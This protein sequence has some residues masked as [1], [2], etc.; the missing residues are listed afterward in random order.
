M[1]SSQRLKH[2]YAEVQLH[3]MDLYSLFTWTGSISW[4]IPKTLLLKY[5]LDGSLQNYVCKLELYVHFC[6]KIKHILRWIWWTTKNI[7]SMNRCVIVT[8][9]APSGNLSDPCWLPARKLLL[10]ETKS[11]PFKNTCGV[12]SFLEV[13]C[14][15][16]TY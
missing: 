9:D 5:H 12:H 6:R 7:Y 8:Q 3:P 1:V 16:C 14:K 15:N 10:D 13:L 11:F 2:A 4:R